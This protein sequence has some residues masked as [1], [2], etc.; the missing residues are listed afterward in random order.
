MT[1]MPQQLQFATDRQLSTLRSHN[2][3]IY[4]IADSARGNPMIEL[5]L[6][7]N[8]QL[9][10]EEDPILVLFKESRQNFARRK[11]ILVRLTM[12]LE[13]KLKISPIS[14]STLLRHHPNIRNRRAL[15]HR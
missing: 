10:P 8:R 12:L 7:H 15:G 14:H 9:I 6:V 3:L 5:I 4:Q 2:S 13:L 1:S 11:L